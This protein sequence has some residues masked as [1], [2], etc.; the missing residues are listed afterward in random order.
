MEVFSCPQHFVAYQGD[1]CV[2]IYVVKGRKTLWNALKCCHLSSGSHLSG[3]KQSEHVGKVVFP[4]ACH[5]G[6]IQLLENGQK[7]E[8]PLKSD[9]HGFS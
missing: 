2:N 4:V 8:N 7:T 9:F 1:A 5:G 3:P 6:I